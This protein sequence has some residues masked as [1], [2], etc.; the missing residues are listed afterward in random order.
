MTNKD[1]EQVFHLATTCWLSTRDLFSE[2]FCRTWLSELK[3]DLK[4]EGLL[5]KEWRSYFE[6]QGYDTD[7]FN[8]E[9]SDCFGD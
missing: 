7:D 1:K 2:D 5:L 9:F 3:S 4:E 8:E 6:N